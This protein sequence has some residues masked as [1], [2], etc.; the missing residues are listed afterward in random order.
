[1]TSSTKHAPDAPQRR[2]L[3]PSTLDFPV[4]G[5]GASAGGLQ[6]VKSFFQHMPYDSG[7]AFV[8]ILHLSPDHH[9]IVDRI[10]QEVTAMPVLQVTETT[11]IKKNTVYV[12]PPAH[13]LA[14]ATCR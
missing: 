12:I 6:A 14:M 9:S 11:D 5:I 1:M 13:H 2:E 8:V 4:V 10:I 7:M 3:T